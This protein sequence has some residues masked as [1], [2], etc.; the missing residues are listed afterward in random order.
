M[1]IS[2]GVGLDS[3]WKTPD[4]FWLNWLL[5]SFYFLSISLMAGVF[6]SIQNLAGAGWFTVCRRVAESVVAYIYIGGVM[7]LCIYWGL[8]T[9]YPWANPMDHNLASIS[10]DGFLNS[11]DYMLRMIFYLLLWGILLTKLRQYSLRQDQDGAIVWTRKNI[12]VSSIFSIAFVFAFSLASIEWIMSVEPHWYSTM[13]PWYMM[14]S[15][16]VA[17]LAMLTILIIYLNKNGILPNINDYHLHDLAKYLF[18]FS[19]FWAYLWF[20]QYMLI[21]YACIPEETIYYI[22][23]GKLGWQYLFLLNFFINF[24]IPFGLLL[25]KKIK[26]SK[27]YLSVVCAIILLGHWLD[28][29]LMIMP[30]LL[31]GGLQMGWCEIG[32]AGGFLGLFLISFLY[33]F[34]KYSYQPK[35]DPFYLESIHHQF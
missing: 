7:L 8:P 2:I 17:S 10:K 9:I 4:R 26:T 12:I 29:Y 24:I 11:K 30:S 3:Y 21:W 32:L 20:S 33:F 5:N 25:F 22:V 15:T 35:Q 19:M 28:F 13:F 18:A 14:A 6:I 16:F 31:K 1:L 23:R 34:K 27:R